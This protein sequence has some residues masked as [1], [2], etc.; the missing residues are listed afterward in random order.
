MNIAILRE[1][2][3]TD[4]VHNPFPPLAPSQGTAQGTDPSAEG[5]MRSATL[6]IMQ[7][8]RKGESHGP[9]QQGY[10]P[11][12]LAVNAPCAKRRMR[13]T[14]GHAIDAGGLAVE[15]VAQFSVARGV[16]ACPVRR[17]NAPLSAFYVKHEQMDTLGKK[18]AQ[19]GVCFIFGHSIARTARFPC[20]QPRETADAPHVWSRNRCRGP[21]SRS[22]CAV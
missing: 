3:Y 18:G 14:F 10:G 5:M 7:T 9:C 1:A 21:R 11:V 13:H 8:F 19:R 6:R 15:A 16:Q 17:I 2:S 12:T 4:C 22:R 20:F